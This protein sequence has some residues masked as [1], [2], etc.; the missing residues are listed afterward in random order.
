MYGIGKFGHSSFPKT[1]G[2]GAHQ[3]PGTMGLPGAGWNPLFC[4]ILQTLSPPC[5]LKISEQLDVG[6]ENA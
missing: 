6:G 2:F 1:P 5:C 3:K 4:C